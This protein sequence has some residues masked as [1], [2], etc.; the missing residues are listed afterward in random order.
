[1]SPSRPRCYQ[2]SYQEEG[3]LLLQLLASLPVGTRGLSFCPEL[4]G[5]APLV[6]RRMH[7]ST[8]MCE[9]GYRL[10]LRGPQ[11]RAWEA[12]VRDPIR[13]SQQSLQWIHKED[14]ALG[15]RWALSGGGEH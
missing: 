2:N 7:T 15:A 12:L 5:A 11:V 9:I 8:V 6:F 1:M 3:P 13:G 10:S 14:P 4:T